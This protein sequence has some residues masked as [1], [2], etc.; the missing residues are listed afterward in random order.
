MATEI[1]VCFVGSARYPIPLNRTLVKKFTALSTLADL[2]VIGFSTDARPRASVESGVSFLLMPRLPG[3]LIRQ[4]EFF[5]VAP[6]LLLWLVFRHKVRVIVAQSPYEG[7]PAI[8]V[9]V[10][11]RLVGRSVG[12]V[13]ESHGDFENAVFLQRPPLL[14]GLV[15]VL[16][17]QVARF[18]LKHADAYRAVSGTTRS[19]LQ[20]WADGKVLEEFPTWTDLDPFL[21]AGTSIAGSDAGTVLYAGVLT[22]LKG[23][24]VL[25]QA[26]SRV[27]QRLPD[28]RL[29][30]AGSPEDPAYARELRAQAD[31]L[32]L[33][34]RV[35]FLG[36]LPQHELA[37]AMRCANLIVHPSLSEGLPRV[38]IEAMACG[39]PVL[40]TAVGGIPDVVEEAV[41]GLLVPPG[42]P[43]PLAMQMAWVLTHRAEAD[44]IGQTARERVRAVFTPER[45]T[46]GYRRLFTA[47]CRTLAV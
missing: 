17:R 26:F 14:P 31:R 34:D 38:L 11:G 13:V 19:L 8:L 5:L 29:L 30:L 10:G 15:R 22:R 35:I 43:E 40:A 7:V 27:A 28:A 41:T 39:R 4:I 25:L 20:P 6:W 46:E 36:L 32:G 44:A 33:A 3:A 45:Y 42:D 47:A 16:M 37:R 1:R 21:E 23:L 12:V 2:F 18:S 9:K 24:H